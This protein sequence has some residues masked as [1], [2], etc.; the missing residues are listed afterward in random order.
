MNNYF[1]AVGAAIFIAGCANAPSAIPTLPRS[2]APPSAATVADAPAEAPDGAIRAIPMPSAPLDQS[3][4]FTRIVFASC[5]QQNEDQA[6]WDRIAAENPELVLYIGDNV[7][8]DVRSNDPALPELKAAYMRLAQ[9]K[10]FAAVR[11]ASPVLTV[12]DDHDYG[13]NDQGASYPYKEQSEALFHYV[14]ATSEND[15]RR[16]RPGVYG[17]WMLGEEV[18]RKIQLIMLDTRY[19]RS[20]LKETDERGAKGKERYLP[21]PDPAKTMLGEAQWAWLAEELKKPADLRLLVSSVQVIAD[22]HGWEA[23]KML[24]TERERLYRTI[25]EAGAEKIIMLSGD[26]HAAAFYQRDDVIDYPL[27]E[28]TSSSLNLPA[29]RWREESGETY[30]EPGLHRLGGM[31][32][33]ANYGVIDIDWAASAVTVSIKSD[34]GA[35]IATKTIDLGML[36]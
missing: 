32:F 12:W 20:E 23:W 14:W 24:P 6:I 25:D 22:G 18:G 1:V 16:A 19:F 9:S 34:G 11:E 30:V 28:A 29:A 33:E 4:T 26:R 13:L 5:A 8:G 35:P 36:E 2:E 7:Y 15:A 10:P 27:F 17:A 3:K 21:D 31:I